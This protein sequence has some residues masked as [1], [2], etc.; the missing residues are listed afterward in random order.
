MLKAIFACDDDWGIGK[1]ND[2]PWPHNSEDLKWFKSM[3]DGKTVIMGRKTW[4]SLPKKPLP[5]RVNIVVSSNKVE[6]ART[7]S[8]LDFLSY[9]QDNVEEE[10]WLIGGAKLLD[11]CVHLLDELWLSRIQGSYKCDTFLPRAK[12]VGLMNL[13]SVF[14]QNGLTIHKWE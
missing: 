3:T 1:D 7:L 11:S 5:N 4:E 10:I 2:L 6:G 9:V 8:H 12:V 14:E 13:E